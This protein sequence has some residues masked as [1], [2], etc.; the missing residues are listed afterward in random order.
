MSEY[1]ETMITPLGSGGAWWSTDK[2]N[3]R[4][5]TLGAT[6][7]VVL[8]ALIT[9]LIWMSPTDNPVRKIVGDVVQPVQTNMTL[10]N[11]RADL[12]DQLVST[13]SEMSSQSAALASQKA[14]LAAALGKAKALETQLS[15]AKAG[16]SKAEGAVKSLKAAMAAGGTPASVAAAAGG[17]ADST[18]AGTDA[19][20]GSGDAGGGDS[21]GGGTVGPVTPA[22]PSLASIISPTSRYFGLY[23]AQSPF[24]FSEFNQVATDVG[25]Q[26]NVSGYFQGWDQDFRPE[27]VQA[28]WAKGDLPMMTWE[29]Q[30]ITA[31][32]NAA[33]QP[34]Y[35]LPNIIK[36]DFD[37]YLTKYADDIVANGQPLAIRLDQEM[38]ATW[39]PWSEDDGHGKSINGNS[40]GDFVKMWQHVHDVFAA[41]GANKYVAWIWAPNRL[42]NLTSSHQ[43][44]EYTADLYP[45]D[46]Y[47][48]WV[49]MSGYERPASTG[50]TQVTTFSGTFDK[51]LGVLRQ[52]AP[53]KK[54]MLAEV[55]A[56]EVGPAGAS[57]KPGWITSFFEG[58]A[59]PA[60]SDIIGFS[61]FNLA[62]TTSSNGSTITND[63]RI[64][65]TKQSTKAFE[66]G[67]D[68]TDLGYRLRPV[69][70]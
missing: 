13:K 15:A 45:G 21:G 27:A 30:P 22:T 33:N 58:L 48:D 46:E 56:A 61:W 3:A 40:K 26:P 31:S 63:W 42:D 44:A 51:T 17:G 62:V 54:I 23:T 28:S 11:D 38:N 59:D 37:A 69:V 57:I 25:S 24:S 5:T 18:G 7:I 53:S 4:R 6:A 60:N 50:N 16:A 65:S 10:K 19:G 68:R 12:L 32:N 1:S 39:Y 49:G 55:G 20:T 43:T 35:S 2:R 36:G 34:K 66:D 14:Q 47:V 67:I 70:Q 41:E 8:L 29:S 64:N 9:W 52:V